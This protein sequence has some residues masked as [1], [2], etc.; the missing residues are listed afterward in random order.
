MV[1]GMIAVRGGV[2]Q[3]DALRADGKYG[4]PEPTSN[5]KGVGVLV[6]P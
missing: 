1:Y 5:G 3:H 2:I 4:A 6:V